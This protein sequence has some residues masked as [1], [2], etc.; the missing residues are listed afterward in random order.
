MNIGLDIMGGDFAPSETLAGISLA[1]N[2]LPESV[3]FT[4]FGSLPVMEGAFPEEH[5]NRN[6]LVLVD[7]PESIPMGEHPTKAITQ[8]K[9]SSIVKG[10]AALKEGKIDAF[11]GA[12]NTGAMLVGGMYS[13][14]TIPGVIRPCIA[15]MVPKEKGGYG[16]LL[17]VG[18]NADCRADVLMQFGILGSLYA[19]NLMNISE[20]RIGLMNIGEE[21][22]K[23]NLLTMAAHKMLKELGTL[24]FIGNIE[25]RDLFNDHA[26]VIVTD[27][28]TGN[29]LLKMAESFYVLIKRRRI[30]DDFFN[31]F[32]Y[33]DYG[34]SPILG[35]NKPVLIGHGISNAKAIKNM[36]KHAMALCQSD[37]SERI[38]LAFS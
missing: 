2:E 27:G 33:E 26:D 10:F 28:F 19:Q 32:N 22:E 35:L 13:V 30:E 1:L 38:R 23:G 12:G 18:A 29:V 5:P 24:N 37:I 36:L 11:A 7:C 3:N 8:Y 16:L 20:P 25:G 31:L 21:E 34:G 4:L 6:R 9:Q 14:K 17:D 15:S